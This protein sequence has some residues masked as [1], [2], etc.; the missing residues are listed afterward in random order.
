M[1]CLAGSAVAF[2]GAIFVARFLPS[3]PLADVEVDVAPGPA[4][5]EVAPGHAEA[6]GPG[7]GP[8]SPAEP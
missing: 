6:T 2:A 8:L 3:R 5:A 7:L 1:E 4:D